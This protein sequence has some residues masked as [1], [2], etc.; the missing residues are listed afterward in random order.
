[1]LVY[2]KKGAI[3]LTSSFKYRFFLN[4]VIFV[5][6]ALSGI[7]VISLYW[8]SAS[9]TEVLG[10]SG[11]WLI[12]RREDDKGEL[13]CFVMS[14]EPLGVYAYRIDGEGELYWHL[15]EE[16]H[17]K[18]WQYS[19]D[20]EHP[21]HLSLPPKVDPG[22]AFS[23]RIFDDVLKGN[24]LRLQALSPSGQMRI[25]TL[26]LAGL[27]EAYNEYLGRCPETGASTKV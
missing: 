7:W 23:G 15:N 17:Q 1:M 22:L 26:D 16:D 14:K 12:V 25:L 5:A 11:N 9:D 4:A 2:R 10:R 21:R 8:L 18:R 27:N 6:L 13:R 3:F 19:I 24:S 20:D